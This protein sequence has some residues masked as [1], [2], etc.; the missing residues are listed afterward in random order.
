[1]CLVRVAG[2]G[3]Y[4]IVYNDQASYYNDYSFIGNKKKKKTNT[5]NSLWP[6][7]AR[8]LY[9]V[10]EHSIT[11]TDFSTRTVTNNT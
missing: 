2:T 5:Y 8:A 6:N 3:F 11:V 9:K 10:S 4:R 1:M 7:I